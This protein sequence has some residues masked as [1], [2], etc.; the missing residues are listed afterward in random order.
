MPGYERAQRFARE[1]P[2][3]VRGGTLAATWIDGKAFEYS[4]DGKR[5]H[6]DVASRVAWEVP[7]VESRGGRGRGRGGETPE[8]GRQFESA[9]SPNGTLKAF[10]RDRNLWLSAAD[11]SGERAITTDGSV[12][13]RVKYGTASWVYGEELSQTSAMWW[14]PDSTKI[15]YYRFDEAPVPDYYV[16]LNQ[17]RPYSTVDTEAYPKAGVRQSD[18]RPLRLRRRL[19]TVDPD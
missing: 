1:T 5:F 18:R 4:R 19:E 10:Y 11:G 12:S 7:L 16:A 2:S 13:S 3:A 9:P 14:S 15:A 17:T 8:R 6:Y